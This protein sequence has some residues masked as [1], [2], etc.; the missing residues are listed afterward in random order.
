MGK[1]SADTKRMLEQLDTILDQ[2]IEIT[3]H[4]TGNVKKEIVFSKGWPRLISA[5]EE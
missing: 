1:R 3:T 2:G 5:R 4:T